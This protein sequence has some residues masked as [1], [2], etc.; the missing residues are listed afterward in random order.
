MRSELAVI[1]IPPTTA[2]RPCPSRAVARADPARKP[3]L[4]LS[5]ATTASAPLTAEPR[6][7]TGMRA[8][9]ACA[10][11]SSRPSVATGSMS[12]KSTPAL[13]NSRIRCDW[14]AVRS[15]AECT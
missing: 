10:Q 6:A 7:T 5:V 12:T 4:V 2:T 8:A 13:T 3:A 1:G 9:R 14:L 15:L 11:A